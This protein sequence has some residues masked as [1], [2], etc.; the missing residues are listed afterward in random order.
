MR[1]VL[2]GTLG[3][4]TL[5]GVELVQDLQLQLVGLQGLDAQE[6]D[7]VHLQGGEGTEGRPQG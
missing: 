2:D 6:V 3:H 4:L 7:F 5:L 1:V